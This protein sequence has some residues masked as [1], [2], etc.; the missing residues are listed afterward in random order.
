MEQ[1]PC[2]IQIVSNDYFGFGTDFETEFHI[3]L[4]VLGILVILREVA[5]VPINDLRILFLQ[6]RNDELP[7]RRIDRKE[8]CRPKWATSD[9]SKKCMERLVWRGII[10]LGA[11]LL[12]GKL[13]SN[14]NIKR[15]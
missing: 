14:Q 13:I 8:I 11:F 12:S 6:K 1:D 4:E 5:Y 15:M 2:F 10:I 9:L 3:I 7:V